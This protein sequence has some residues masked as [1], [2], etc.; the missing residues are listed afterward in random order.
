MKGFDDL[1][2]W[3]RD[4]SYAAYFVHASRELTERHPASFS[5]LSQYVSDAERI[6][7]SATGEIADQD[8]VHT[9]APLF[10]CL[11]EYA[12]RLVDVHLYFIDTSP[13]IKAISLAVVRSLRQAEWEADGHVLAKD[14]ADE[15]E[16]S[17]SD[18]AARSV[19]L[20]KA[21]QKVY[22]IIRTPDE[23]A[24]HMPPC[25]LDVSF[26]PE[27]DRPSPGPLRAPASATPYP[28]L[29]AAYSLAAVG[30][31]ETGIV[32]LSNW[33]K[34]ARLQNTRRQNSGGYQ[35]RLRRQPRSMQEEQRGNRDIGRRIGDCR[36]KPARRHRRGQ[37]DGRQD[38]QDV[39]ID[40]QTLE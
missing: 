15:N 19:T 22:S 5:K 31:P 18:F 33:I 27:P 26:V 7:P 13:Q 24:L 21:V 6:E 25:Y 2:T 14:N 23:A 35:R 8:F 17:L 40:V 36:S 29:L 4:R 1:S 20:D 11:A 39:S 28:A 16:D 37:P 32:Y 12:S 9:T 3:D 34:L 30:S 38:R 10:A